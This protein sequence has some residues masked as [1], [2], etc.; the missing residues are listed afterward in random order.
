M[1]GEGHWE[2]VVLSRGGER[3]GGEELNWSFPGEQESQS[4]EL[5]FKTESFIH[6]SPCTRPPR[7][8]C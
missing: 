2:A 5:N 7:T 4:E 3:G 8:A 6:P 1:R